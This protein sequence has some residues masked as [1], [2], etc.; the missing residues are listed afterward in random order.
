MF[1]APPLEASK[2]PEPL[3]LLEKTQLLIEQLPPI[4]IIPAP[5]TPK[6]D[7]P[8]RKELLSIIQFVK[9]DEPLSITTPAPQE[10][11]SVLVQSA[12]L[13]FI[14]QFVKEADENAL[15]MPPPLYL[16]ITRVST[17][18]KEAP[19][20]VAYPLLIITPSKTVVA[21]EFTVMT[22]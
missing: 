16:S 10:S 1:N 2:K 17:I 6:L 22:T 21:V 8:A 13:D 15:K 18:I 3:V 4:I 5:K 19:G 14:V 20:A 9:A 12:L 11:S 7:P